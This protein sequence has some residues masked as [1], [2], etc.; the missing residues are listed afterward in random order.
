MSFLSA[1]APP[2]AR[3]SAKKSLP[4]LGDA[5]AGLSF[6]SAAA[7][8][9]A[10]ISAK[11]SLPPAA[12]GAGAGLS[13]LRAAA[14][15]LARISARKSPPPAAAGEVGA[16]LSFF[17]AAALDSVAPSA[18][19]AIPP[20]AAGEVG[21]GLSFL[22]A[23]APPLALISAR[24]SPPPALEGEFRTGG[25]DPDTTELG[26]LLLVTYNQPRTLPCTE[27]ISGIPGCNFGEPTADTGPL[28]PMGLER[29]VYGSPN[30][31]RRLTGSGETPLKGMSMSESLSE[32]ETTSSTSGSDAAEGFYNR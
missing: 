29:P 19:A 4:P 10:L 25:G 16:G 20:A 28:L 12:A 11:K 27:L 22:S 17:E 26:L 21:A 31:Q 3:I 15:P 23:D 8:P 6:L 9:L 24:K 32:E 5:G 7:P 30:E 14:P 18:G 13:F 2:L 1:A